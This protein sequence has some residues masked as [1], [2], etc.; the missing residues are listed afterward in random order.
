MS[1]D[2]RRVFAFLRGMNVGGRRISNPDLCAAFERI[3]FGGAAAFRAAGNVALIAAEP[4]DELVERIEN[5]LAAELGYEVRTLI[6]S[7]E[8]LRAIAGR[9]PF[10][11][12]ELE[13]SKGKP[14][15]CLL[16]NPLSADQGEEV[17]ARSS[18]HDRLLVGEREIFWLPAGGILDSTLDWN[19]LVPDGGLQ[20]VR[21]MG[22]I[23]GMARK[24]AA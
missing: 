4:E 7:G 17:M 16:S 12:S 14:Q 22:T 8:E 3:G 6:R 15:V 11:D 5:G 18:S 21:T 1:G 13:A 10:D 9:G 20:T 19:S 2:E 23:E 24:F